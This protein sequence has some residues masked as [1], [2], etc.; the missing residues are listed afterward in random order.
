MHTSRRD[1]CSWARPSHLPNCLPQALAVIPP[2]PLRD[3]VLQRPLCPLSQPK[4]PPAPKKPFF[5]LTPPPTPVLLLTGSQ[6]DISL[7]LSTLTSPTHFQ[8]TL[9]S[10]AL[11]GS[12][13]RCHGL[14]GMAS[15]FLNTPRT[16][17]LPLSSHFS[18][19]SRSAPP[20]AILQTLLTLRFSPQHTPATQPEPFTPNL[21]LVPHPLTGPDL[22]PCQQ[23]PASPTPP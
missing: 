5:T 20:E 22:W 12:C 18:E 7:K 15:T 13:H 2:M 1:R 10:T 11:N 21:F 14:C 4:S 9:Q 17:R 3:L 23:R 8:L 19:P 6:P 16:G